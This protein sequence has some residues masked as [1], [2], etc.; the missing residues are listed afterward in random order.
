MHQIYVNRHTCVSFLSDDLRI[1]R[2]GLNL[3]CGFELFSE[4]F[5]KVPRDLFLLLA[6][7]VSGSKS[8]LSIEIWDG[9]WRDEKCMKTR[10]RG[11]R[12]ILDVGKQ[13]VK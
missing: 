13:V 5:S 9:D 2:R 7:L 1:Q 8:N 11:V 4:H 12:K 6:I 3:I 10:V